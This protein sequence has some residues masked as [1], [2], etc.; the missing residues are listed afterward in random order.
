MDNI[1]VIV[2][3]A[4]VASILGALIPAL[5]AAWLNPVEALRFE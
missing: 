2:G 1:V 5:Y 4:I 3:V